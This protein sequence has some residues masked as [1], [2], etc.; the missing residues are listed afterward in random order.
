MHTV[1]N[2]PVAQRLPREVGIL[3]VHRRK[4]QQ[5][6]HL[7]RAHLVRHAHLVGPAQ[8][9]TKGID[10]NTGAR[11]S[12]TR[13]SAAPRAGGAAGMCSAAA[14]GG[15]VGERESRCEQ[16][17]QAKSRSRPSSAIADNAA[18]AGHAPRGGLLLGQH[19]LVLLLRR[20]ALAL[21]A[22]HCVLCVHLQEDQLAQVQRHDAL[23]QDGLQAQRQ[24][25]HRLDD[26][27]AVGAG[28]DECVSCCLSHAHARAPAH[29]ESTT[30]MPAA[31]WRVS[32]LARC[33]MLARI[34]RGARGRDAS[35]ERGRRNEPQRRAHAAAVPPRPRRTRSDP[36]ASCS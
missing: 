17:A 2:A 10:S 24:G 21:E 34:L 30:L 33:G 35:V 23:Q 27:L 13:S 8:P 25:R 19:V 15:R 9:K 32:L 22:R 28:E 36:W 26:L 6:Q 16:L 5:L 14:G 11:A 18:R 12:A 20:L 3:A 1:A 31:F 4:V 29:Q 7:Q